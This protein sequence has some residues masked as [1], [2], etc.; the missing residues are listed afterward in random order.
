MVADSSKFTVKAVCK[1]E[2]EMAMNNEE[3]NDIDFD[4]AFI[5]SYDPKINI[6]KI[7]EEIKAKIPVKTRSERIEINTSHSLRSQLQEERVRLDTLQQNLTHANGV[8]DTIAYT[9]L[10]GGNPV[11]RKIRNLIMKFLGWPSRKYFRSQTIF[12]S[13]L[14]RAQNES[15]NLINMLITRIEAQNEKIISQEDEIVSLARKLN[16]RFK[17][18][19]SYSKFLQDAQQKMDE[20][21]SLVNNQLGFPADFDYVGF[22]N[23]YRGEWTEI[24]KRMNDRYFDYFQD[25]RNVLDLGCGRGE[26][27]SLL[28]DNQIPAFGV[29][30]SAEMIEYCTKLGLQTEMANAIEFVDKQMRLELDGIFCA[31]MVEHLSSIELMKF[32]RGCY[33]CMKEGGV[34]A[35][36]TINPLSLATH[37]LSYPLDFTHRR[38]V[39]PYTLKFILESVGFSKVTIEYFTPVRDLPVFSDDTSSEVQEFMSDIQNALFSEQ[40]YAVKAIK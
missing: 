19:E 23:K 32:I 14:V 8:W 3:R 35:L 12:N 25:C 11:K 31:Q 40:D 27:L 21:I 4:A 39:H 29:D 10:T 30:M 28:R 2:L 15:F 26:F 6:E 5:E 36:E 34:I 24:R 1:E 38:F 9:N 20:A 16:N 17:E 37:R 7:Q 22:E 13:D 33:S 18:M